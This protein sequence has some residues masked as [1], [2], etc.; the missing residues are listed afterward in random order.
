MSSDSQ[1]LL[2]MESSFRRDGAGQTKNRDEKT[3]TLFGGRRP[4]I[5]EDILEFGQVGGTRTWHV[6][7]FAL[8]YLPAL[9]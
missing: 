2:K 7:L 9:L 4:E 3:D 8:Q 1:F 6:P 5:L